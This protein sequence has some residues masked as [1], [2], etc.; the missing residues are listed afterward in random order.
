[1]AAESD[2]PYWRQFVY[3]GF[4]MLAYTICRLGF[5]VGLAAMG[6]QFGWTAFQAGILGTIFLLGQAAIDLPAGYWADRFD[7][8]RLIFVGLF[9][10]GLC[11]ALV[12]FATGFWSA[13]V[14]RVLFGVMEGVYNIVQFAVAGSILPAHRAL[15]NGL[16]QVFF[17]AGSYGGQAFVGALLRAHPGAWQ[18]PLWWLGGLAMAYAVVS[19][20]LFQR[21]YLR[22]FET[23]SGISRSGFWRTLGLVVCNARVWQALAIHACNITAEWAILGLGNYIFIQYRHYDP[24]FSTL[25][26]GGGFG[27]GGLFV[28]LGTLWADRCGR[29]PVVCADGLWTALTLF[30]LFYVAPPNWT[31]VVLCA[32]A[33]FGIHSLYTLGYTLTQDAV[34]SASMSGVGIATGM[35]GGF[36]YL[37]AMLSGP[38]VGALVPLIGHLWAMNLV[39][40]GCELLV[41]VFAFW[42]LKRETRPGVLAPAGAEATEV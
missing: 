15:V 41:A 22:R 36:G 11:T 18:L 37:F 32:G 29:R 12:T 7:R 26:F 14:Y 4:G 25:V 33:A 3:L 24:A 1:M 30:L 34:A 23:P 2:R 6:K 5:P 31:M 19:L 21:P 9:G 16:T 38:L 13:L 20:A 8:K 28:P 39:V 42:F 40:I 27:V 17:G 10:L 35:A